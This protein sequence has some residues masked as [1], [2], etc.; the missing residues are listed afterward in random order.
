MPE[1][2]YWNGKKKRHIKKKYGLF[3]FNVEGN[4]LV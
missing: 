1:L 2:K 3:M 4:V